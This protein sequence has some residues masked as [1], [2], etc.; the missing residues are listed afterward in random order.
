MEGNH[1]RHTSEHDLKTLER[2]RYYRVL[3]SLLLHPYIDR[4]TVNID[5]SNALQ[6]SM[7]TAIRPFVGTSPADLNPGGNVAMPN[8]TVSAR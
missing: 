6:R 2:P 4:I 8:V 1:I 5:R 3:S 7:M